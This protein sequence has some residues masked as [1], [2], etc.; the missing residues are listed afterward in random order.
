MNSS[1]DASR[2]AVAVAFALLGA[3]ITGAA[4]LPYGWNLAFL[5]SG[6]VAAPLV[7]LATYR[8]ARPGGDR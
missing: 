2:F 1:Q 8:G 3:A 4:F 7:G 6:L 5:L